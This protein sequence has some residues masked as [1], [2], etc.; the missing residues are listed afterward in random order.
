LAL[1]LLNVDLVARDR[2]IERSVCPPAEDCQGYLRSFL[3][4]D[5]LDNVAQVHIDDVNGFPLS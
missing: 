2:D 4:A 5:H 1:L 3:A